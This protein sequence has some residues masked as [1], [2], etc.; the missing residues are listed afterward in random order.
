MTIR[1]DFGKMIVFENSSSKRI[2]KRNYLVRTPNSTLEI[3]LRSRSTS[4]FQV[5][6]AMRTAGFPSHFVP[7]TYIFL[8][9]FMRSTSSALIMSSFALKMTMICVFWKVFSPFCGCAS[10]SYS[11][12][13]SKNSEMPRASLTC[14]ANISDRPWDPCDRS[15]A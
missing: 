1:E 7:L 14:R 4:T 3:K 8:V 15:T 10:N 5:L 12:W 13:V 2:E 11:P 6:T 9:P